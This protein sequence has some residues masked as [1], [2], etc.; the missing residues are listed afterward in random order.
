M[1]PESNTSTFIITREDRNVDPVTLLTEALT[2]GSLTG[3]D[4]LL[5][6]PSVSRTHAGI[7]R[8]DDSFYIFN[9]SPSNSTTLNGKLVEQKAALAAGDQLQIGTFF[10]HIE[11]IDANALALSVTLKIATRVGETVEAQANTETAAPVAG[12]A[13]NNSAVAL[14]ADAETAAAHAMTHAH[15]S[16]SEE[17]DSDATLD[18]FWQKRKRE[19]GKMERP[20]PLHPHE[21]ARLGKA[22]WNWTP[23]RDLARPWPISIL[24]W[25]AII[26]SVGSV[27][28]ALGYTNAFSPAPVSNPHQRAA[29]N[30]TPAIAR[31]ANANSC[32]SCH[33]VRASMETRCSQ[34]HQT[35]SFAATV[36]DTHAQAGITC[37]NCHTE[38][39][40]ANF[41]PGEASLATCAGCHNDKNKTLFRGKSVHTPHSGTFG[42]PVV[43]GEWEWKG[44]D[45]EAWQQKQIALERQPADT[46]REWRS[47]QFHAIHLYRV[48]PVAGIAGNSENEM[49]CSSCHQ[50]FAP[51]DRETPRQTCAKCHNGKIEPQ[52]NR[53]LIDADT[54]NCTSC[55]VQHVKDKRHWNPSLLTSAATATITSHTQASTVLSASTEKR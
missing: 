29:L 52:T 2:I 17:A 14:T 31:E 15:G 11:R 44:L 45:G 21:A 8:V 26:V 5:N 22:R 37:T 30:T 1:K 41:R 10:L 25:G 40:G 54:A 7:K 42:Y 13:G 32:T 16:T 39:R 6:H 36:T 35:E 9:L 28:A 27:A 43:A 50:S 33:A 49:S 19:A 51:I 4:L 34:C 47:K 48:R 24:I 55:H 46:E 18:V 12:V 3:C 53:T 23:T 38:H 20:S